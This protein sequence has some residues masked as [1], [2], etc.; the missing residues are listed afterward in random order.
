MHVQFLIQVIIIKTKLRLTQIYVT[1]VHFGYHLF[2][3]T[4]IWF[5]CSQR[6]SPLLSLSEY[7]P[8]GSYSRNVLCA[9]NQIFVFNRHFYYSYCKLQYKINLFY[10]C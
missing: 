8:D 4:I 9:L 10:A 6:L 5:S 7:I 2:L 3:I 1:L